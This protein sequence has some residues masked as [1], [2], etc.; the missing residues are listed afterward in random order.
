METSH[1]KINVIFKLIHLQCTFTDECDV[2]FAWILTVL[3][4]LDKVWHTAL[5]LWVR[6]IRIYE[7]CVFRAVL[8]NTRVFCGVTQCLLVYC[9]RP[10]DGPQCRY[11][12]TQLVREE[13]LGSYNI[14][15]R[16]YMP[17]DTAGHP[18]RFKLFSITN[19]CTSISF[20][21]LKLV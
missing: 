16:N 3:W 9:Y 11:F 5:V 18:A 7:I 2:T 21:N 8:L 20:I 19:E 6:N 13:L 14:D 1:L 4:H 17:V 15:V 10:S 12:L